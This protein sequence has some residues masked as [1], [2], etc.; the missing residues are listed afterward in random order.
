MRIITNSLTKEPTMC[1]SSGVCG[2]DVDQALVI[3]S[4]DVAW[5]ELMKTGE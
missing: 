1:C 2:A 5:G 4:A 3:F